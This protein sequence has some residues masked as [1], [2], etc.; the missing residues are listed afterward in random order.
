MLENV[1]HIHIFWGSN[2]E[3][4]PEIQSRKQWRENIGC[5]K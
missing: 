5:K 3:W 4:I 2:W 1:T